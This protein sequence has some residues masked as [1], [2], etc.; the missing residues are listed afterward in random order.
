MSA[1]HAYVLPRSRG[2]DP[3]VLAAWLWQAGA[4]GVWIRPDEVEASFDAV[5]DEVPDGG[6]WSVVADEDWLARWRES[7]Q[8][9]V[10]GDV[11]VVP[12]W[13]ADTTP[14]VARHRIVLDPGNA[15]GSGHHE[16]TAGCLEALADLDLEGRSVLDV[17]TGTGILAMAAAMAGA[18]PVLA[19]DLDPDAVEVAARNVTDA[20]LDVE[21]RTG[22][23]DVVDGAF[24]VV[25]A[26]LL[27]HT[28]IALAEALVVATA[29][30]GN[31]VVSGVG[32][33][34]AE[35]VVEA[36]RAAGAADVTTRERGE[37]AILVARRPDDPA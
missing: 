28:V 4:T 16:T 18:H 32:V 5:T 6:T 36:L 17:G 27:T 22:S 34:R 7:V 3:D 26:N 10:A 9:I 14:Q 20:G 37:W 24:D 30:G 23:M 19:V 29:P 1:Y 8:P 31:L 35:R 12:T 33:P 21:T 2:D 15:F 11:E 13:L 25:V